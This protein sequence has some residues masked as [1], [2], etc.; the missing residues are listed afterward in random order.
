MVL[1][2]FAHSQLII[3][4]KCLYTCQKHGINIQVLQ[5]IEAKGIAGNILSK[6]TC[7]TFHYSVSQIE[8]IDRLLPMEPKQLRSAFAYPFFAEFTFNIILPTEFNQ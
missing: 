4:C 1:V 8:N 6:M 3:I 7:M 5:R 2:G